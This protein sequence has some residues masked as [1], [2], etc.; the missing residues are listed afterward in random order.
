MILDKIRNQR[1]LAAFIAL[2]VMLMMAMIGIAALKISNDEISIA[3]NE[4]NEMT[5]FY[6]AEAG[7]E[8]ASAV[9][10]DYYITHRI[11][12]TTLPAGNVNVNSDA[13]TTYVTAD[14]G[15]AVQK[16][17]QSGSLA[18]LNALVK[19]FRIESIGT[20]MIDGGQI[21]LAQNFECANIPIFQWAVFFMNDLWSQPAFN[22]NINGRVHVNGDMYLQASQSLNFLNNVTCAG[23]INHGFGYGGGTSGD[24][25]FTDANN[26]LISMM[27]GGSWLDASDPDWYN[28]AAAL[29]HGRVRDQAFGQKELVL[30][31]N[32]TSDPHK[33]IER[34]NSGANQDSY[35]LKAEFKIINGVPYSKTGSVW[36][37]VSALL[38]SGTITRDNSTIFYDAHEKKYTQNTQIDMD[39]LKTSGYFPSNGV[40]YI[41]DQSSTSSGTYGTMLN[42]TS[43]VNGTNIGAP[44]TIACENPL[45]VQGDFNTVD[46]QPVAA[47]ADAITYLSNNWDPSKSG[48]AYKYNARS[49]TKTTVNMSF[50]TGDLTPSGTNYGGGLEN[51][52]RFLEDWNGTTFSFLGSMIEGWRSQQA[53]GTWRYIQ[54][55]DAYYSAPRRD[56]G[57]DTDLEDPSK[58]PPETPQ[59]QIFQRAGWEQQH[60]GYS[61]AEKDSSLWFSDTTTP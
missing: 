53:T 11:A 55:Y 4:L 44:L 34:S 57:F 6:A 58:L 8:Q 50:I 42:T 56:W 54:N 22:M 17:L 36:Q 13:L 43:L 32:G 31:L 12:P 20:S 46:K 48:P 47:M 25:R 9:I 52:P 2:M 27:Q 40:V 35:E 33:I 26:N 37:D 21:R 30:P 59:I 24:V 45:Y 10:Q 49:A 61:V 5:A 7:L 3:G 16:K 39:K 41:S 1:G 14:M 23:D 51:L 18:G 19:T 28:K 60:L 29:W 38:P 15:A